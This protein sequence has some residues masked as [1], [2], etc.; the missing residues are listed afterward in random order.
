M[1]SS[2]DLKIK[3]GAS[4]LPEHPQQAGVPRKSARMKASALSRLQTAAVRLAFAAVSIGVPFA[5]W[6]LGTRYRVRF[7]IRFQDVPTPLDVFH[8]ALHVAGSN[9][10]STNIV[11]SLRRIFL[12]FFIALGSGVGLGLLI[13]RYRVVKQLLMPAIEVL[14]PIP[15]I[16]WV[17]LS[18]MLW[19]TTESSIV[20]ITFIGAFYPI[21][22]NTVD[23]VESLDGVLLRA[24]R[25]LGASEA[26]LFWHVILPG[27][28]PN[29]FTGLAVGM[30]VAWVSLIAAEMIAGQYGVGYYTWEAYSLV[31][32]PAIVLGMITIGALGLLSSGAIRMVGQLSMP[33]LAYVKGAR[34]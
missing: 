16:A 2:L 3:K 32:Y 28:L 7:Y 11:H 13:G 15:A 18:I 8:T 25:C 17:P 14:R 12:G 10:F 6:Y 31:N 9:T 22:L 19:P 26:Q 34:K 24:G 1:E 30:G 4:P 33:W 5:L 20:F 21:L 27:V 29:I 23:G